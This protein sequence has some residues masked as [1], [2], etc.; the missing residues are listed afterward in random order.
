MNQAYEQSKVPKDHIDLVECHGTGTALGDATEIQSLKTVFAKTSQKI[1]I[2]SIKSMTGHC[3]SAAGMA[4]FLKVMMAIR[5]QALPPSIADKP[6]AFLN[7]S[8]L[9]LQTEPSEW[10]LKNKQ[11][12]RFASVSGFGFGGTNAHLVLE[13]WKGQYKEGDFARSE[14]LVSEPVAILAMDARIGHLQNLTEITEVLKSGKPAL[15]SLPLNRWPKGIPPVQNVLGLNQIEFVLGRFR[16]T[17]KEASRLLPQQLLVL[18]VA[19]QCLEQMETGQRPQG[20]KAG[21]LI[22][23]NWN[24]NI[25]EHTNH[26]KSPRIAQRLEQL[27]L[28]QGYEISDLAGMIAEIRE[29]ICDPINSDDVIGD[30]PNFP[31]NRISS[32]FNLKGPSFVVF[33]EEQAGLYALKLGMDALNR[34][35]VDCMIVGAVDLPLDFR[36]SL[37]FENV[38]IKR[39][40]LAEGAAVFV[41]RRKSDPLTQKARLFINQLDF[42]SNKTS[43]NQTV[44]H[45]NIPLPVCDFFGYSR[46]MHSLFSLMLAG[47]CLEDSLIPVLNAP[48]KVQLRDSSEGPILAT[49]SESTANGRFEATLEYIP[50]QA[51]VRPGINRM[52]LK[53]YSGANPEELISNLLAKRDSQKLAGGIRLGIVYQDNQDLKSKEDKALNLIKSAPDREI[54]DPRGSFYQP[55]PLLNRGTLGLLYPGF[56]NL[57]EGMGLEL[58]KTMPHLLEAMQFRSRYNK[59]L[60]LWDKLHQK[61]VNLFDL[62][63]FEISFATTYFSCLGTHLLIEDLK[64]KPQAVIGFSGGEINCLSALGIWDMDSY[65]KKACKDHIFTDELTGDFRLVKKVLGLGADEKIE[66]GTYLIYTS[67]E[68]LSSVISNYKGVWFCMVNNQNELMIAGLNQEVLRLIEDNGFGFLRLP[69]PQ[70]YH[71]E[72]PLAFEK[73]LLTLW[74]N[75]VKPMPGVDFYAHASGEKYELS[76]EATG[77]AITRTCCERVNF[78]PVIENAYRDG[79]RVFVEVGPQSSVCRQ[80]DSILL[81]REHRS[82]ALNTKERGES[83]QIL[84]ALSEMAACGVDMELDCIQQAYGHSIKLEESARLQLLPAG[85]KIASMQFDSFKKFLRPLI[86]ENTMQYDTELEPVPQGAT[87]TMIYLQ[88]RLAAQQAQFFASQTELLQLEQKMLTGQPVFTTSKIPDRDAGLMKSP[89]P[90]MDREQCLAFANGSI[91]DVFGPDFAELDTYRFRTRYPTPPYLLV[92]RIVSID[93][94]PKQF[95]PGSC[96][97]EFDVRPGDYFLV[98]NRVPMCVSIESGQAD[99]FLIAYMGIDFKVEGERVYRLLGADFTLFGDLPEAPCTLRYDIHISSFVQHQG[100]WLFFFEGRGYANGRPFIQWKNGC[101]GYFTPEELAAKAPYVMPEYTVEKQEFP[102]TPVRNCQKSHFTAQ[103][104]RALVD[105][106]IFGCFGPGFE[107]PF[108]TASHRASFPQFTNHELLMLDEVIIDREGG[109]LGLGYIT[110]S[111]VLDDNH[112]YFTSHF[113]TDNVMPGTLMLDG[114]GQILQLYLMYLGFGFQARNPRFNPVPGE[115]IKVKCRGQVIPGMQKLSYFVHV[116]RIEPGSTPKVYADVVMLCDGKE[117]VHIENLAWQIQYDSLPELPK[118]GEQAYDMFGRAVHTNETQLIELTVGKP[119]RYFGEHY[120]IFDQKRQISRMPNPPYACITRVLSIEGELR[121]VKPGARI[122][123]EYDLLQD[124]WH[125]TA[126]HGVLPFCV[127]NEVVL[128][129]CGLLPQLLELDMMSPSDR[130]IRNLGG[131]M[132][133]YSDVFSQDNRIIADVVLKEVVNTPDTFMVKYDGT[134]TL[135]DGTLIA[136]GKNLHFGFFSKDGLAAAPGLKL[137]AKEQALLEANNLA[138]AAVEPGKIPSPQAVG[139]FVKLPKSPALFFDEVVELRPEGGRFKKGFVRVKK[140]VDPSEWIFYS[141][142]YMDSVVPGS[143]SLDACTQVL[144]YYLLY[145]GLD[146][147]MGNNAYFRVNFDTWMNWQYRGQILQKNQEIEYVLEVKEI[148]SAGNPYGIAD[149]RVYCDKKH[150]YSLFDIRVSICGA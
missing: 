52:H 12:S 131:E 119:S 35:E 2:G 21:V 132:I 34:H 13:E 19:W 149:A 81:N 40:N 111:K 43:A 59:T 123:N 139:Q 138:A 145:L 147:E 84:F 118:V 61:G 65:Y 17:P 10:K 109:R 142:F 66:W 32:E 49:V 24:A 141:H 107:V 73:E 102:Y 42:D 54:R 115:E 94:E 130:F 57:Y 14:A 47:K 93:A 127:L 100:I 27:A 11:N 48:A 77:K 86:Q 8:N 16:I 50:N 103:D 104:L 106:N 114:C 28:K 140:K 89:N 74:T 39:E 78:M 75:E 5:N 110:A 85:R 68:K 80:V 128:Q 125:F 95:K 133:T 129:P 91:V 144:K 25:S 71:N 41:L 72:I 116:T 33:G 31:A 53:V 83:A 46:S 69:I 135:P 88:S 87:E 76:A 90:L 1:S 96:V 143:Y 124:D 105:G 4:S 113:Y 101:A 36:L 30:I 146:S 60:G 136:E 37:A 148:S 126:N 92:D 79:V 22:G 97:T 98:N 70:V 108:P 29:Q 58:S 121:K 134:Y 112:W 55:S 150:I 120:E 137:D 56:G 99:L 7:D 26:L 117:V 3:L 67:P 45:N 62:S 18:Q 20:E 82:I 44:L 51:L 38:S 15:G 64:M 6:A 9:V 122:I 23:M 63:V